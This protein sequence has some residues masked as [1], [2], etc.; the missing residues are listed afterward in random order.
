VTFNMQS[1]WGNAFEVV[2]RVWNTHSLPYIPS[3]RS[4][5]LTPLLYNDACFQARIEAVD[6]IKVW[7]IKT[8]S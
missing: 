2:A 1:W 6:I 4:D 7:L 3:Q 5:D 8:L